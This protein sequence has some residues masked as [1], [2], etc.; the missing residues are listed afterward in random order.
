MRVLKIVPERC[1]GCLRCE[2]ACSYVQTGTFQ[3]AK[4]VIRVS[5]FEG[6]TS[7]A[8]YTCVQCAE[9]WCMTACPVGAIVISAVGAKVVLDDQCV[10][11]KLC[12]IACPYGT[13]FY[14]PD[15]GRRSSATSLLA[16]EPRIQVGVLNVPGGPIAEIARL[17]PAFRPSL[18]DTLGRRMP[19]LL[20][21]GTEFREDLP[22]RGEGPVMAPVAGALGIQEFLARAEW[23]ARRGDPLAYARHLR[24]APLAGQEPKRVLIQFATG[25]RVVPNPTTAALMRAGQLLDATALLR[26]DRIADGLPAELAEPHGFLLRTGAPGVAGALARVAQEQVA[27]FFASDGET[28]W[29]PDQAEP[30]PFPQPLFEV[31]ASAVPERL[32]FPPG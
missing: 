29:D 8:P 32:G 26:Y 4:S 14:N 22:L 31:P 15:T 2:Y 3:P 18:R 27:R 6:H 12:A 1:T 28:I 11:C 19:P 21:A 20:N 17:S 13:M 7:Y 25:D 23:L 5:P 16:V 30:P 24:V 10:G 9:G